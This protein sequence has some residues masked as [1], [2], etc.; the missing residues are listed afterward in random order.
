MNILSLSNLVPEQICDTR[1]FFGRGG[2]KRI[3]HYCQYAAD[4]ISR[5][6]DDPGI[7]GAVF[8]RTCDSCR[9]L[10][11]YLEDSGKFLHTLSVPARRDEGGAAYLAQ[12]L[13]RYKEAVEEHYKTELNDI[14]ERAELIRARNSALRR[15]YGRLPE[16]SYGAYLE[17]I[18]ALLQKPLREQ[19]VPEDLPKAPCGGGPKVFVAGSTQ[20]G[21]ELVRAVEE[22]GMNIVGDRLPE[23]RRLIFAPEVASAG[24]IFR[25]IAES[26]L[27]SY[28]SPTQDDF[29]R[30]LDEDRE[31]LLRTGARGVIFLT[32]KY[33]EPYDYLYPAYSSMAESLG[34][35]CLRVVSSGG[36]AA[37]GAALAIETFAG[38]L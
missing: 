37:D 15:L 35:K 10:G 28:T 27:S 32:Q 12:S 38:L 33:C 22:A 6:L 34:V 1:R 21:A 8:P 26:V 9:V 13:R 25:N 3:S 14:P 16:L 5:A 17:T 19:N 30:I 36:E 23:S 11:A 29:S 24:D 18:H 20:P 7:D 31:E 2:R 4:F